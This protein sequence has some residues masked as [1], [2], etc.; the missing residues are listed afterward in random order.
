MIHGAGKST[1]IILIFK[2]S[3][4]RVFYQKQIHGTSF[5]APHMMC[6]GEGSFDHVKGSPTLYALTCIKGRLICSHIVQPMT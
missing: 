4:L 2:N 6:C 1:K 5:V 3:S